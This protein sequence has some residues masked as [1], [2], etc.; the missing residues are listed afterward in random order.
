[1]KD[2]I[3]IIHKFKNNNRRIQY[4]V[5]VFVGPLVPKK[6][7]NILE[8]F[9][10]KDLFMTLNTLSKNEFEELNDFYGDYWYEKFFISYHINGMR[11]LVNNTATKKKSLE[12]KYGKEWYERHIS[13]PPIKKLSYSF[14]S[15]YYNYMLFRNK[16]KSS[17]RKG[18]M[19]FRTKQ[20]NTES[21]PMIS[22]DII[23]EETKTESETKTITGNYINK[24]IIRQIGGGDEETEEKDIEPEIKNEDEEEVVQEI[25][26]ED[27]DEQVEEDINLEE[28][29]KLYSKVDIESSK[30]IKETS[31]LISD[32]I[33]DKKWEKQVNTEQKYD[34][35]TDNITYDVR[36][37]DIYMKY[38]ITE[39]YIFKDDTIKSLRNKIAV[40]LPI[41][42]KF[43]KDI[44]VL[45]ETQ[46]F[47]SEYIF[48]NKMDYVMLGQKWIRRNELLKIDVVPNENIKI[49]EKLRNNLGY[50]KDTFG[51]K[52]KR[53]DDE[54]NIIRAYDD[55]MTMNEIFMLD[56]YNDLGTS[57]DPEPEDKR[58]MYDVYINIYYPMISY[59]RLEQIILLLN[60]KG[61]KENNYIESAFMTIKNDVKLESHIEDTVEEAKMKFGKFEKYF[62]ENHIIHS[63]IHINIM[64]PKNITGTTSDSKFNLYRI[65]DNFIVDMKYPFVQYQT[66]DS[67]LSYKFFTE[68]KEE[69]QDVLSKWFENASYGIAFKIKITDEK[70][71]IDDKYI[72]IGL[73]ESGRI[74]YKITWK[75]SDMATMEDIN[76]T[77]DYVR[78]LL[79]KINSENKKI[80][81]IMPPDDRFKY[82]FLNSIQKFS[83]PENF[84]INHNDLSDFS[85]FFFPYVSLQIDP[86]KRISKKQNNVEET[87][88]FGTYLRYKRI[89]KYENRTRMHLRILYFLRNYELND[90]ELIDEMAKQ[91]NIT[92]DVAAKE[93]DYVK[94]KY[95]RVIR[96]SKKLLKK[97]K[98]MPK[99]KLPGIEISIQGRERDNYKIRITGS[100]NKEQLDEIISFMKVLIYLYVETYLYKKTEFNKLKETLKGL[101]KIAKRRNLVMDVV[102]HDTSV[103]NVKTIIKMDKARL[104]FKP[105][106]GQNQ[107][108]RSCQNSG[109]NKKRQPI[110]TP[111][112]QIEKLI[113]DGYMMNKASGFYEKEIIVKEK[114]KPK[115]TIIRAVR[116]SGADNYNYWTCDH[117]EN[118]EHKYIGFLPRGNNPND[119]C[120]P[121]CFKKDQYSSSNIVKKNY[122]MKCIG[123]TIKEEKEVKTEKSLGDKLYILQETNKIQEDRFIQLP[124]YLE[125]FFNKNWNHTN[126][127]KNHYLLES[128]TGYFF[129]Y[130]VKHDYYH[131]LITLANIYNYTIEDI[132]KKMEDFM[133]K[134]KDNKYFTYLNNGDINESF[135]SKEA[136]IDYIKSSKYLDYDIIGELI[137]LPGLL[138]EKGI[139]FYILNKHTTIVRKALEKE[140]VKEK[141]YL[142]CLNQENYYQLNED[143]DIVV[144][145]KDGKYY[146]PIYKVLRDEKIHKKILL[147]KFYSKTGPENK[148][149]EEM[150]NYHTNSCI[151]SLINKVSRNTNLVAKNIINILEKN[152]I[153]VVKQYIDDRHKCKYVELEN[154]LYL[155]VVP[156]GASY[157]YPISSIRTIKSKWF[158]MKTTIKLLEKVNKVLNLDF[159]PNGIFYDKKVG[160]EIR[161]ISILLANDLSLPIE[162]ETVREDNIRKMALSVRFQPLE[163]TINMEIIKNNDMEVI[164]DDRNKSVKEHNYKSESYNLYRLELSLY[165]SE[166]EDIRDKIIQIVRNTKI[167][168]KDKRHE[169]RKI[170]FQIINKKLAS[171]YM[172]GGAKMETLAF[173][174]KDTPDLKDYV[175][176]NVRD[177]CN[178]NKNKDKCNANHHCMWKDD[179]CKLAL[180]ENLAIDFVNKMVEEM[181]ADSIHF[182]EIIQDGNYYVSDIVDYTQFTNRTNQKIIKATNFNIKKLMSELFGKDKMPTIGKKQMNKTFMNND[183][184]EEESVPELIE[185]GKQYVM[186]V[187][188]NKDS[189]IRAYINSYYWIQNTLYDME[190]RNLGYYNDLQT[191]MTF[192]FKANIIDWIQNNSIKT[193]DEIKKYLQKYNIL[194]EKNNDNFFESALNKFRKSSYNTDGKIELF[195]LSHLIQIPIV[196]YD[197]FSNVKYIFLQGEIPVNSETIKNFTSEKNLNKTIFLKFDFDSSAIPKNIYSIYYL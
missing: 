177:Y 54:T 32:A 181:V 150:R 158:D 68:E 3:K 14:A 66:P 188:P 151:N 112:E 25:S 178:I 21:I 118:M 76:K 82:A 173:L 41:S 111:E 87:S 167:E 141:Y 196:V 35:S 45:P 16:I 58:N 9:K 34:D 122:F 176:N 134:D 67:Q 55:F 75:E 27:F 84:K 22:P 93:L 28:L 161:I 146:F 69:N 175:I 119:L 59:E 70:L 187:K 5:Y 102:P 116:L 172:I 8:S 64:D 137:S 79:K 164:Y 96:K 11:R 15:E 86:K 94:D 92:P 100:R 57:Y 109:T 50:L 31:K 24:R 91:F 136:Y 83:I 12:S 140:V 145:I 159:I 49:Y 183:N 195:V 152:K 165:L 139:T 121:C 147:T 44:K 74:D 110:P 144:L 130:T 20:N 53:E 185:L 132:I 128:K 115:K 194:P 63:I 156:S 157:G 166:N 10:E 105:E 71:K 65:F 23:S 30:E 88:K 80:K 143:R 123:E 155:P 17:S 2:P 4:K 113:K 13:K 184:V 85:R 62:S 135:K 142:D 104:G 77:Y 153:K 168:L 37:E 95:Q 36:L 154:G 163:E 124:K 56:V 1:M 19:D 174:I 7:M 81:F 138:S 42:K 47:W 39:Q 148:I 26:E 60:G 52:I 189:I 179:E 101:T 103:Q 125:Y 131:F 126:V 149:I 61:E 170:L 90:R 99:T 98:A 72:S 171:D 180:L 133:S 191:N 190:S 193:T 89:S 182:K 108:S 197:N 97:L 186:E 107:W 6:I 18:E 40:S 73:H 120:M 43:G 46:Y 160:K 129:K 169:L 38:Y 117:N 29:T 106:K 162:M 51:Y 48:E 127:I 192:L 33:N 78:D 114:G